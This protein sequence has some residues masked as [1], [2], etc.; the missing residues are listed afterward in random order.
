MAVCRERNDWTFAAAEIVRALP[1]LPPG[2][3]R[4]HVTSRLCVNAPANH[5]HRWPYFRRVGRGLY[6]VLPPYRR[7]LPPPRTEPRPRKHLLLADT[8]RG[9]RDTAHVVVSRDIGWYVA[10]CLEVPVVAQGRTLDEVVGGVRMAIDRKLSAEN[11]A[12]FGLARQPRVI[13]IHEIRLTRSAPR[14]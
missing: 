4:T 8:P 14:P 12:R 1:H 3:I 10:E 9:L 7:E 5:P 6:E 13:V 2:T 11:A